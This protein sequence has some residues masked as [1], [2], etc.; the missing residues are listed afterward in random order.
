MLPARSPASS[1]AGVPGSL[2]C[3]DTVDISSL[4]VRLLGG[5]RLA[6]VPGSWLAGYCPVPV[7]ATGEPVIVPLVVVI[8]TVPGWLP[9]V[10]GL[11]TMRIVHELD[12]PGSRCRCRPPASSSR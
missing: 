10:V 7:S 11:N 9:V 3:L 1:I 4:V 8:V 5:R 12:G 6:P 2:S